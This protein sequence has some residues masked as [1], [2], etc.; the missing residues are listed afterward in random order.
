MSTGSHSGQPAE[1]S[2]LRTFPIAL[3][4]SILI[5][6]FR[7]L[8]VL[9]CIVIILFDVLH[10]FW[11]TQEDAPDDMVGDGRV[12]SFLLR[13][14]LT[15]SGITSGLFLLVSAALL[16][17]LSRYQHSGKPPPLYT[18]GTMLG[19]TWAVAMTLCSW[20][21]NASRADDPNASVLKVTM[22]L[23]EAPARH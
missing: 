11:T 12:H 17:V 10:V 3:A 5:H 7:W 21:L 2:I 4:K 19:Y 8:G 20:A 22:L 1:T 23:R 15:G 14:L 13:W 16:L 6:P 18:T 9:V